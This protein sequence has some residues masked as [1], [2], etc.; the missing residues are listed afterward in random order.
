MKTRIKREGDTLVLR[1]PK[2]L[3]EQVGLSENAIVDISPS[4]GRIFISATTAPAD[5]LA[6][7]LARVTP[8]NL[9]EEID[10]GSA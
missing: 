2:S 4:S 8:E 6:D 5:D 1:I 7:L 9:H 10:F 3:A